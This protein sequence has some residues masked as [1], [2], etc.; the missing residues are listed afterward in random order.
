M[1]KNT[2][3]RRKNMT[4]NDYN[5]GKASAVKFFMTLACVAA[6]VIGIANMA[7]GNIVG[8]AIMIASLAWGIPMT[9]YAYRQLNL[10]KRIGVG[11][12]VCVLIFHHLIAGIILLCMKTDGE[13]QKQADEEKQDI[14]A[15]EREQAYFDAAEQDSHAELKPQKQEADPT[16]AL[17]E[18]D[19]RLL[20]LLKQLYDKG[21]ITK[22]EY[23][24]NT[25][26]II[27]TA[28]K[29]Y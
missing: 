18:D 12:K 14:Q 1:R 22:E 2:N 8:G 15:E 4:K 27:S 10:R 20:A 7:A 17:N 3:L 29:H 6:F 16:A 9:V 21:D 26:T 28:K 24:E 13:K 5:S 25:R 23:V 11:F 19:R